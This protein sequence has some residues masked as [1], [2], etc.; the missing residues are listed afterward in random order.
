MHNSCNSI[1]III[2]IIVVI[3]VATTVTTVIYDLVAGRV[4][5]C[6]PGSARR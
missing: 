3:L 1:V 6:C 4:V 5:G 2:I